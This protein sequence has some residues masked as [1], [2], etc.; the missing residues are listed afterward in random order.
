MLDTAN[1]SACVWREGW[2]SAGWKVCV[3][4]YTHVHI[5]DSGKIAK[6]TFCYFHVLMELSWNWAG[7]STDAVH[8][9]VA[10]PKMHVIYPFRKPPNSGGDKKSP[11]LWQKNRQTQNQLNCVGKSLNS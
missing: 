6:S 10:Y 7:R 5:V 1:M 8:F 4:V 2:L 9:F 11:N 3:C